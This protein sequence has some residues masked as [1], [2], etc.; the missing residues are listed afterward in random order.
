VKYFFGFVFG[1]AFTVLF[2]LVMWPML[3][4]ALLTPCPMPTKLG[5]CLWGLL[6]GLRCALEMRRVR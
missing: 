3:G 5:A 2:A 1:A 4:P 6:G